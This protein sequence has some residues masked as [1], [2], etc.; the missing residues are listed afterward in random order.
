MRVTNSGLKIL[1]FAIQ[2]PLHCISK[3]VVL[4]A[5]L[6][7]YREQRTPQHSATLL[8]SLYQT[9]VHV[10]YITLEPLERWNRR[11][12]NRVHDLLALLPLLF[13][14]H[15]REFRF[16]LEEIIK[17]SLFCAGT[18]ANRIDRRPGVTIF[19]NQIHSRIC[20]ALLHVTRSWHGPN[21][22]L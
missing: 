13:Q 15:G 7:P 14:R 18:L 9:I 16:R 11:R 2:N 1:Y 12:K 6:T 5:Y 22:P 3:H 4:R 19:P 20:Q 17:A 10:L 8:L 21:L